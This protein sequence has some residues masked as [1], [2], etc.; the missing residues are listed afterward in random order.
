MPGR[1]CAARSAGLTRRLLRHKVAIISKRGVHR[2]VGFTPA[3]AGH[4]VRR[5][6]RSRCSR[7]DNMRKIVLAAAIAG[8]A[9]SLAGCSQETQDAAEDTADNAMAD[10][11][12]NAEAA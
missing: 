11:E 3:L 5:A 4:R 1:R 9:L 10:A 12:A 6:S 2:M 8:A 7:I